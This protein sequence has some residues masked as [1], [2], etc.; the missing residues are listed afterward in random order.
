MS[1]VFEM[2]GISPTEKL[3]LL[4]LA[5][6]ADDAGRCYPSIDRLA[7]RTCLSE[8]ALQVNIKAL[9]A[10]GFIVIEQGGGRGRANVYRV[11]IN[12][13]PETPFEKHRFR[14]TVSHVVNPAR[15]ALNPA[16]DAPQPSVTIIEPSEVSNKTREPTVEDLLSSVTTREA[17]LS[18]IAY[19]KKHKAKALTVVAAKKLGQTLAN[20]AAKGLDTA[21]ALAT[22]EERGWATIKE[23]WYLKESGNGKHHHQQQFNLAQGRQ[24]GIDPTLEYIASVA[25]V[26]AAQGDDWR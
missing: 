8:R 15:R 3:I 18:F 1:G 16:P 7:S 11:D 22:A 23:D 24:D 4:A 26:G 19:R 2:Q 13:A 25:G 9:T 14:N 12:P 17:A 21:D 10:K 5:D 20:M 6:H